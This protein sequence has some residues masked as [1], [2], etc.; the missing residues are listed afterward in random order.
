[1]GMYNITY[2]RQK[3]IGALTILKLNSNSSDIVIILIAIRA[4]L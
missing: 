2:I 3:Y 1:M 4:L